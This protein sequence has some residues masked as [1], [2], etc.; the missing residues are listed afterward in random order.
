MNR[1]KE[2]NQDLPYPRLSRGNIITGFLGLKDEDFLN[3]STSEVGN[4]YTF[5]KEKAV[6]RNGQMSLPVID[7]SEIINLTLNNVNLDDG[8][9][10]FTDENGMFL[11]AVS[12]RTLSNCYMDLFSCNRPRKANYVLTLVM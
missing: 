5:K 9:L 3:L 4:V 6:K 10:V 2:S 11:P 7:N 1:N 8:V 12:F